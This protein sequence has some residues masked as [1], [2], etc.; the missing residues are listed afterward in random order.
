[1]VEPLTCLPHPVIACLVS[2]HFREN[3]D[4]Q[5]SAPEAQRGAILRRRANQSDHETVRWSNR[6]GLRLPGRA[7][8]PLK[9]MHP[10]CWS[11]RWTY[12]SEILVLTLKGLNAF[13]Y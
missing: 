10:T 6:G 2:A 3:A 7:T 8:E 4:P 12:N 9:A 1:M 13:M 5:I 11:F